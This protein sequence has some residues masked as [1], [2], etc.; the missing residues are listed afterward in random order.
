MCE[1]SAIVTLSVA[2]PRLVKVAAPLA[3][4][5]SVS[6]GSAVAVVAILIFSDPSKLVLPVTAPVKAMFLAVVSLSALG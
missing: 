4:P 3:S 1:S 2:L 5:E 6:V